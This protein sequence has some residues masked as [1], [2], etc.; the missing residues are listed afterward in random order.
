M[1]AIVEIIPVEAETIRTRLPPLSAIYADGTRRETERSLATDI[2][3]D[4]AVDQARVYVAGLSAGGAMAAVMAAT[5]PSLYAA[6]GVHSGIAYGAARDV[7]SATT[8]AA[9]PSRGR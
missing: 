1:P 5:Y 2:L 9:S 7:G 3:G 4:F 6:V 8:R